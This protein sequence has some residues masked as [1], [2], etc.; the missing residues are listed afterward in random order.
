[1]SVKLTINNSYSR[2]EGLNTKQFNELRKILS[3]KVDTYGSFPRTAYCIDS[4]GFFPSGLLPRVKKFLLLL[5]HTETDSRRVPSLPGAI[6]TWKGPKP[7]KWQEDAATAALRAHRGILAA[8]TGTGKSLL[9]ALIASR[10]NVKTLVV[11]PNLELKQQLKA[12]LKAFME[13][14]SIVTVENIDSKRLQ[15]LKNYDCLIIDEAHHAAAKTYRKLHKQA[16]TCIFYRFCFT[17]TPFRNQSDEQLLFEGVAGRPIYTLDYK[18]AVQCGYI[19]PI[20]AYYV[21]LPKTEI[22]SNSW[23]E[24]YSKLV[25]NN[26][27]RNQVIADMLLNLDSAGKSTLCLVK[28]IKHGNQI[29]ALTA[30]PF[31][32]GQD[33]AS[34]EQIGAYSMGQIK[35][36][37]G[38]NGIVGEGVDTKPCEYVIIGGLGKAKSAFMQQCGRGVR[39]YKDKETAKIILFKDR[40]HKFTLRHFNKQK[41]ILKEVYGIQ[42]VKL[43]I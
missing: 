29:Q 25:V 36:L 23:A 33:E 4:K 2:V 30:I 24:V 14:S 13:D 32:N 5:P 11:V 8:T 19:C 34:R 18:T 9:I 20:E 39:R 31:A 22:D 1:M 35:T 6:Q 42:P 28:E 38:T 26:T 3:Y 16:W 37:I 12:S 15:S 43:E 40:S 17:A 41:L 7:F 27:Y 21:D 10:L